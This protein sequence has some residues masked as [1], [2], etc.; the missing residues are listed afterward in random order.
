MKK[1]SILKQVRNGNCKNTRTLNLYY[2]SVD[3]ETEEGKSEDLTFCSVFLG[4]ANFEAI[5]S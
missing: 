5:V 2:C 3:K 1:R 4:N